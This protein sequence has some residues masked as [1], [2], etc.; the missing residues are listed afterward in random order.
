MK[1]LLKILL[2]TF[3]STFFILGT[4]NIAQASSHPTWIEI[5]KIRKEIIFDLFKSF[6]Y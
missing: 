2:V 1:K 5:K 4:Y 3:V 6:V